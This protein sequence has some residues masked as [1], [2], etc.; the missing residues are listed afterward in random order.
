MRY[1]IKELRKSKGWTLEYLADVV[2]T[3]KGYLSDLERGKRDGG[4]Q[5]LRDIAQA[6]GVSEREIFEAETEVD[7]EILQH[8]QDFMKLS[9][10]D[11]AAVQKHARGLLSSGG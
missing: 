6:L 10:E 11:R 5:M 8:M 2:G 4:I 3:S 7:Q 9:P 1:R